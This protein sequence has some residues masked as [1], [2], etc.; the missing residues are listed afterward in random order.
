MIKSGSSSYR[1][2]F[3]AIA[4]NVIRAMSKEEKM[5]IS[6]ALIMGLI[7]GL[8]GC[9]AA[10]APQRQTKAGSVPYQHQQETQESN[11]FKTLQEDPDI[12]HWYTAPYINPEDP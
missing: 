7:L 4:G 5:K 6:M 10:T 2:K 3:S 1:L 12:G 8:S 11:W 9:A